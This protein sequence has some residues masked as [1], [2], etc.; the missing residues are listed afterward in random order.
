[1]TQQRRFRVALAVLLAFALG[2]APLPAPRVARAVSCTV[3]STADSGASTLRFALAFTA[4]DTITFALPGAAPWTINLSSE[5]VI[6]RSVT[7]TGPGADKLTLRHLGPAAPDGGIF[8]ITNGKVAISGL[9]IKDDKTL[10]TPGAGVRVVGAQ[11]TPTDVS[12]T[13]VALTGVAIAGNSADTDP[14]G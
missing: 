3:T 13:S 4:C 10:G 1:M 11:S 7:I 8:S 6:D 12:I 5:L 14:G 2:L 9:T